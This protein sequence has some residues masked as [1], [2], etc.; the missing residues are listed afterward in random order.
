MIKGGVK[1]V[2]NLIVREN[3]TGSLQVTIPKGT[4][5]RMGIKYGDSVSLTKER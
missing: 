4:A 5:I 3:E 2:K 1:T